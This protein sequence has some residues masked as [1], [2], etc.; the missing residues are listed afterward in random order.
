MYA[1]LFD[2]LILIGFSIVVALAIVVPIVLWRI[3]NK[4]PILSEPTSKKETPQVVVLGIGLFA[5]IAVVCFLSGMP[6]FGITFVLILVIGLIGY[7]CYKKR[8][9]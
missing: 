7:L 9:R 8:F 1:K 3:L 2:F 6:Y 4:R 5:L